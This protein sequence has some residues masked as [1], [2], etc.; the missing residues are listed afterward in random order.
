M[1]IPRSTTTSLALVALL[2]CQSLT[3]GHT[4]DSSSDQADFHNDIVGQARRFVQSVNEATYSASKSSSTLPLTIRG[5]QSTD[6]IAFTTVL[7]DGTTVVSIQPICRALEQNFVHNVTCTCTGSSL[8]FFSI[9]CHY[10]EPVCS[11]T[12]TT[13]G[14]PV[15]A[16]SMVNFAA[17]SATTCVSDYRR[18]GVTLPDVCISLQTC[19]TATSDAGVQQQSFCGC[20]AQVDGKM[21]SECSLCQVTGD[22]LQ[23]DNS[24]SSAATAGVFLNCTN[25]NAE[26]ISESCSALDLDLDVSGI[27]SAMR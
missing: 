27:S 16:L 7:A 17:F 9:T 4:T 20:M 5:L 21:C 18:N 25:Q 6:E 12:G 3:L 14:T 11:L 13:C 2:L 19:P 8:Q 26:F 10:A 22:T 15:L 1:G 23:T 24:P